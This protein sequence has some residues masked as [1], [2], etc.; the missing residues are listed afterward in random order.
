MAN[1]EEAYSKTMAHEGGYVHD[2]DD[3][4]GE[5][6][7]GVARKYNGSWSGWNIIDAQKSDSNFPD[8]LDDIDELQESVHSF[9]KE[10][11]W[12][13]NKLDDFASQEVAVEMF[14]TGVN[15]G[16]GRAAKFLQKSLNYLN[17]NG[18][19]YPDLTV[20]GAIGGKS[21]S[22]LDTIFSSG[23]DK[24]L[25]TMLNVLQGN[26]YMEYMSKDSTQEKYARGW[27]KRV[28]L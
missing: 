20:D 6:Y 23:D 16:V 22:A 2:P 8:C 18:S 7:K 3:V 15:M 12:D 1:F 25:L 21:L 14:D 26:H 17:R 11:Y 10:N 24:I 13:V 28:H 9:Y 19:L 5:T 4:G 27:F